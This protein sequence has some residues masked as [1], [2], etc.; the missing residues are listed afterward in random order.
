MGDSGRQRQAWI[1]THREIR[2]SFEVTDT[3][4]LV[5]RRDG[6]GTKLVSLVAI[7][8]VGVLDGIGDLLVRDKG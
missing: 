4:T 1:A 8:P 5:L 3:G 2:G 6:A 7:A